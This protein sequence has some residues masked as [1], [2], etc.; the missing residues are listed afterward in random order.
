[1]SSPINKVQKA[2]TTR[3]SK[4]GLTELLFGSMAS[5]RY[6]PITPPMTAVT[7]DTASSS[8]SSLFLTRDTSV[9]ASTDSVNNIDVDV[10]FYEDI[11]MVD[12]DSDALILPREEEIRLDEL[13]NEKNL[14]GEYC[15]PDSDDD[16]VPEEVPEFNDLAAENSTDIEENLE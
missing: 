5:S 9:A 4:R 7:S 16:G 6:A 14:N 12:I 2:K 8:F 1:M 13:E 3:V 15:D 11:S 10:N